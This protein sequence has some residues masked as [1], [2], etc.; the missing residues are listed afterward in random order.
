VDL[1]LGSIGDNLRINSLVEEYRITIAPILLKEND[2]PERFFNHFW[3]T[4]ID[5]RR[6]VRNIVIPVMASLMI[7]GFNVNF[8]LENPEESVEILAN[9]L[10]AYGHELKIPSNDIA[11]LVNDGF[12]ARTVPSRPQA[13]IDT[14]HK[15]CERF[16]IREIKDLETFRR[17]IIQ[18][19][20]NYVGNEKL[21]KDFL[22]GLPL[23]GPKSFYFFLRNIEP[24]ADLLEVPTPIDTNVAQSIQKTGLMF[25]SW[26]PKLS[27]VIPVAE[28]GKHVEAFGKRI[29]CLVSEANP[30][31]KNWKMTYPERIVRLSEILFLL[32]AVYCQKCPKGKGKLHINEACP[33][34]EKCML[35]LNVEKDWIREMLQKLTEI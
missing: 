34:K 20:A 18:N 29:R 5:Q 28:R 9:V 14:I 23:I 1:L 8:A 16:K 2:P 4:I 11:R 22:K 21:R 6:D 24:L 13:V 27:Q 25:D 33:F 12:H 19:R 31:I 32:G 26:P 35:A 7:A 30:H 15:L 3:Y 17:N 10:S